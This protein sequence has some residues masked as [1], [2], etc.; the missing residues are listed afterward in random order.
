MSAVGQE[1][2]CR[3]SRR[4]GGCT[5]SKRKSPLGHRQRPHP[6][7]VRPRAGFSDTVDFVIPTNDDNPAAPLAGR[8]AIG[9]RSRSSID[10]PSGPVTKA[11]RVTG[12][13]V[14]GSLLNIAPLDLSSAQT[15]SMFS[16]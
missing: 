7:G 4:D 8:H 13:I 3:V 10:T 1:H 2:A 6:A 14:T 16:T 15:A 12:R 9:V 11:I 5:P